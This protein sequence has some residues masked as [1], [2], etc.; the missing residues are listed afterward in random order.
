MEK[1]L[2]NYLA[3]RSVENRNAVVMSHMKYVK[4]IADIVSRKL[5]PNSDQ[6]DLVQAGVLGLIKAIERFDPERGTKFCTFSWHAIMGGIK[7]FV[8]KNSG[9]RRWQRAPSEIRQE[10]MDMD[11]VSVD[12]SLPNI[13]SQEELIREQCGHGI[14]EKLLEV[15]VLR[16]AHGLTFKQIGCRIGKS[17]ARAFQ[18][19]KAGIEFLRQKFNP[20]SI[21]VEHA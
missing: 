18:L 1:N 13:D 4:R 11:S 8:R 15:L 7:D 6:N 5:H 17:E 20:P 2:E 10:N 19:H 21:P 16:Y 9:L 3:D 14:T 12:P